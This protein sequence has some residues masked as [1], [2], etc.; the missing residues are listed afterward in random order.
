MS[1]I[2]YR[3]AWCSTFALILTACGDDSSGNSDS[4]ASGSFT[5]T[6]ATTTNTTGTASATGT[7][8]GSAGESESN[9]SSSSN[10]GDSTTVDPTEGTDSASTGSTGE[11]SS[12]GSTSDGNSPPM[13]VS[14]PDKEVILS[15]IYKS[16][17]NPNEVFIA[18]S[19]TDEIRVY[20]GETLAFITSFSHP[21]FS[22]IA[23][24]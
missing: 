18:S 12:T 7:N 6:D 14:E 4:G 16:K 3:V 11:T 8:S 22:K 2:I 17:F 23:S 9:S 21:A 24:E 13:F 19:R 1:S 5:A 10:S 20:D 15:E